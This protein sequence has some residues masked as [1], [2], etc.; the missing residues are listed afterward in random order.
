MTEK[1]ALETPHQ[2]VRGG[3]SSHHY[4]LRASRGLQQ[5][6]SVAGGKTP[7]LVTHHR[8]ERFLCAWR[9]KAFPPDF[10]IKLSTFLPKGEAPGA[11]VPFEIPLA[12]LLACHDHL[13]TRA[14]SGTN[15]GANQWN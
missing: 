14:P 15:K 4:T 9:D 3:E 5:A 12:M 10:S 13:A 1:L 2:S 11:V 6:I 8:D 7:C